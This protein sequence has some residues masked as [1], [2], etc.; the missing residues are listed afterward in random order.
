[1][2]IALAFLLTAPLLAQSTDPTEFYEKKIRPMFA[3]KCYAC[4]SGGPPMAGLDFTSPAGFDPVIVKGDPEQSRLY[5][6]SAF[7]QN[8]NA[9]G[10]KTRRRRGN[11]GYQGVD[12]DGRAA[13]A[14]GLR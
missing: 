9:A 5:R 6:R 4:H 7:V 14:R 12:R 13:A 10:G 3:A 2:R 1:M 8:Q 11:R